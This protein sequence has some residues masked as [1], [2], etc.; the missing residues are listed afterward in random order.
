MLPALAIQVARS[1]QFQ[2]RKVK[3]TVRFIVVCP[4]VL[5]DGKQ[6]ILLC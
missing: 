2:E 5:I 1:E 6:Q 3:K 4:Q